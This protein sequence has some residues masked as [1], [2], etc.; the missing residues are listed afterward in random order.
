M[1]VTDGLH[2]N[3]SKVITAFKEL[4][5]LVHALRLTWFDINIVFSM[6][7]YRGI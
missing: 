7:V 6:K 1:K 4:K 5:K 2:I 3:S